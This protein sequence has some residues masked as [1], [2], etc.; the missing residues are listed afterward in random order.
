[1]PDYK[2]N[3]FGEKLSLMT[4]FC[5]DIFCVTKNGR[6]NLF[7]KNITLKNDICVCVCV[8]WSLMLPYF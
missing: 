7:L 2:N 5:K 1:M 8:K 3:S 6:G 4:L